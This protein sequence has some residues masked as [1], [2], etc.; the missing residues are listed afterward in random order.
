LIHYDVLLLR[1][2]SGKHDLHERRELQVGDNWNPRE[3]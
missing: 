3:E 1:G 2:G